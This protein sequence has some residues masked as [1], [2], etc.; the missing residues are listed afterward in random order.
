MKVKPAR[1]YIQKLLLLARS[2][3][4]F[5]LSVIAAGNLRSVQKRRPVADSGA[6]CGALRACSALNEWRRRA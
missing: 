1:A 2:A 3:S 4:D 6:L 5:R